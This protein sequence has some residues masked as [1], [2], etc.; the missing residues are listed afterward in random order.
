MDYVQS[1][2]KHY[3]SEIQ[4][5]YYLNDNISIGSFADI[6]LIT[7]D[8]A[9]LTRKYAP[10]LVAPRIG[11]DITSQFGQFDLVLSGY[12]RFEQDHIADFE[13][14]TPSYNMVDAK[15]VYHSSSAHDYT[16]FSSRKY[17]KRACL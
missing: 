16:A 9:S 10:R 7:L 6:A 8:D 5:R 17:S 15:L 13:T 11:G 1:D 4:S 3:G 14:N 2:A 12:H